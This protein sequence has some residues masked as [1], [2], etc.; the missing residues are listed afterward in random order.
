MTDFDRW[1]K[2]PRSSGLPSG[3]FKRRLTPAKLLLAAVAVIVMV[4]CIP[5][6]VVYFTGGFK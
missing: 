1:L 4:W 6:A 3:Y 2:A 5:L